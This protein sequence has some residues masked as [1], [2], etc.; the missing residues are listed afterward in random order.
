MK[1]VIICVGRIK[2]DYIK[3]GIKEYVTRIKRYSPIEVLEVKEET[4]RNIPVQKV[5]GKEARNILEKIK[6]GDFVIA[7][8]DKGSQYTSDKFAELINKLSTIGKRRICFVVG[9]AYGL[10]PSILEGADLVLSLSSMT[11][12]HELARLILLEQIYR[13]FTILRNEPYSH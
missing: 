10:H 6:E 2:K 11:F 13:A 9:G 12:P 3:T 5:L 7:L 4:G 1:L 8:G